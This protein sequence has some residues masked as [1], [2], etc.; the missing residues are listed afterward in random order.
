MDIL[1]ICPANCATGGPEAIHQLVKD[2]N[3]LEGVNARI[4]YWA[5]KRDDPMPD[6]YKAY[7]CQYVTEL[8]QGFDGVLIFPEI[9]ADKALDYPNCTR[10]IWWLGVD[11][12]ASWAQ[13]GQLGAFL[14][15]DSII[16]IAQSEYAYTFLKQLHV[17]H[18][19]K[20]GDVLTAC[21][22]DDY[23][24]TERSDVVLYNPAKATEFT[25]KVMNACQGVTFKAIQ[26]MTREEVIDAMRGSKLYIDFGDFPGRER[27]PREA[28]LSG[29]CII[30]GKA[31]AAGYM[32]D[33]EHGYKFERK[34]SHIW[35]IVR[36]IRYVL[37]HYAECRK[38]FD[39]FRTSL[40]N[41][42]ERLHDQYRQLL[43]GLHEVQHHHTGV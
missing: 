32:Q 12:Y 17:K 40:H 8:P 29:C 23:N 19:Y 21:F 31:G 11:A 3:A 36:Q 35:A 22:Y 42:R 27:M 13:P 15:D 7:G 1:A 9:W 34:D 43:G 30:T 39:I 4:W 28:V 18:I 14:S 2:M 16:H 37:G 26:N 41:E 24:E 20:L 25:Y 6:E 10:A 5:V 38:D 33:F